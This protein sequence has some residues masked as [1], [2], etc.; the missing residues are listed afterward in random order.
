MISLRLTYINALLITS[1]L[2]ASLYFNG[3][4]IRFYALTLCLLFCSFAINT[5]HIYRHGW[6]LGNMLI[7]IT[8]ALFWLWLGISIL[9]SQVTYLSIINFWWI[10]VFPLAFLVYSFAPDKELLWSIL[11]KLI[12]L[13]VFGLCVFALYQVLVLD[14]QPRATFYNKN[15]LAALVNLLLFPLIT[16]TFLTTDRKQFILSLLLLF[17][18]TFTSGVI[19]SRGALLGLFIGLVV[20]FLLGRFQFRSTRFLLISILIAIAFITA[21]QLL[22]YAPQT[23]GTDILDRMVSLQQTD[24]AGHSR[25]VIWQPAWQLFLQHPWTG[26]GLGSYFLAIPPTLHSNDFSAGFYVHNDYLQI[27]LET[28]VAGFVLLLLILLATLHRLIKPLQASTKEHNPLR[29]QL[30]GLF[31][32]LLTLAIHSIFTYNLYVMPIM[33]IA[34]LQLA[35][36]NQLA[37]RLEGRQLLARQ[38]ARLFRPAVYYSLSGLI[39]FSLSVYFISKGIAHH[40]QHKGYQLAANNQLEKAHQAFR[41]AQ[42]LAPRVDSAYYADAELLVNS[43][44][45]LADRPALAEELLVEAKELLD[46]AEKLNPLRAQIPYIRGKLLEQAAP[47]KQADIINA[48][49]SALKRNPR[50]LPARLALVH[51]LNE[52]NQQ[53]YAYQFLQDG[54]G[55]SYRQLSPAYLQLLELGSTAALSRG[56]SELADHLSGLLTQ[57]REE[58]ADILS[59]D[60]ANKIINPY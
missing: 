41:L 39:M 14:E 8:V 38:P 9:F 44:R 28:G 36:F 12:L 48:Y 16:F 10:G 40:Y 45:L 43:A 21:N 47:D 25:F 15:S 35:R 20:F 54:L 33:L 17:I 3:L 26:I 5:A 57:Y 27:A 50:F 58:Y 2:V 24:T 7:P 1:A 13:V 55:Y 42:K 46:H 32:A 4:D 34:G 11:N 31:A 52:H 60:R 23:S 56:N 53:D 30:L 6:N 22:Q 59:E 37:D 49:Q 19:N 51:H 29:L 18:F